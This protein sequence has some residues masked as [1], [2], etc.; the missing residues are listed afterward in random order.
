MKFVVDENVSYSVVDILKNSGYEVI[1]IAKEYT[2]L[3][4]REVYNKTIE[5]GAV[6]IT[7]DYH[8]TN[9]IL[10]PPE[11]TEGIIYIRTGNLSSSEEADVVKVFLEKYHLK[12][13]KGALVTLYKDQIK[14]R[15]PRNNI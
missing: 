1:S 10:F 14:I 3:K 9:P 11:R 7:R 4:D 13:F 5:E 2:S 8:F 15:S 6:L 12:N